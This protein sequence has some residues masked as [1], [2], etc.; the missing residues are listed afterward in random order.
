M[1]TLHKHALSLGLI[2]AV[3]LPSFAD[4]HD[5]AQITILVVPQESYLRDISPPWWNDFL[6][7]AAAPPVTDPAQGSL[8]VPPGTQPV[9]IPDSNGRFLHR[10]WAAFLSDLHNQHRN[11]VRLLGTPDQVEK[12]V[13]GS[14]SMSWKQARIID[15]PSPGV[16]VMMKP[17][18]VITPPATFRWS[19]LA[20]PTSPPPTT[21]PKNSLDPRS[22]TY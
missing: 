17:T 18:L 9:P 15:V 19:Y 21:R 5:Q 13:D 2:A 8:R 14:V 1:H 12:L 6:H 22:Q 3:I 7:P 16:F 4:D 11:A 20:I 10:E